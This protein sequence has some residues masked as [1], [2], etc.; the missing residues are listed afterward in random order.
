MKI[1]KS[2][3]RRIIRE[4]MTPSPE[5]GKVELTDPTSVSDAS[6]TQ[7]WPGGVTHNGQ[8]VFQTFYQND[9]VMDAAE[10]LI[11]REGYDV[12][13][14]AYLGYH[15]ESD[16][17]IMGFDA[18]ETEDTYGYNDSEWD[19]SGTGGE[20]MVAAFV[21]LDSSGRPMDF[22]GESLGGMY[23]HGLRE[24]EKLFPG[25]IHVRLD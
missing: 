8:N 17:F 15:P 19:S 1:T 5:S 11:N 23:P 7:A 18:W 25:V 24:V 14:E 2:R 3:L 12:N 10:K 4:Q 21:E 16:V 6:I 9:S 13:Q 20:E 22:A